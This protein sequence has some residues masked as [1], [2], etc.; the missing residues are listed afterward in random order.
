VTAFLGF[1]I[2]IFAGIIIPAAGFVG[3]ALWRI[4][5][6][7]MNKELCFTLL[8]NTANDLQTKVNALQTS[9]SS[10]NQKHEE[11]HQ[12]DDILEKRMAVLESQIDILLN[13]FGL[14]K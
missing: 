3:L 12:R 7:F 4:I 13:H 6:Y 9:D 14:K 2:E 11:L 8:K 10:S 5:K 1:E